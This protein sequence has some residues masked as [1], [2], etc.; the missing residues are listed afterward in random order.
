MGY[1]Y[2][3]DV[4]VFPVYVVFGIALLFIGSLVVGIVIFAIKQIIK[5]KRRDAGS[6]D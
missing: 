4:A 6:N 3:L 1:N 2:F 5:I